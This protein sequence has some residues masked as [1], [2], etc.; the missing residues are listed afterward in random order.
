MSDRSSNVKLVD[1]NDL[2]INPA[3]SEKQTDIVNAINNITIP[4]PVWGATEAKQDNIISLAESIRELA[5][6]LS[7]LPSVKWI[8]ADL[9]VTPLSLPTLAAVTT[10]S[11]VTTVNTVL[12]QTSLWNWRADQ[13]VMAQTNQAAILSNINN[14]TR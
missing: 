5:S 1:T 10:V 12:N 6:L 8:V 3:T 9:R 14:I 7:F 13:L 4:A 11:T 2:E